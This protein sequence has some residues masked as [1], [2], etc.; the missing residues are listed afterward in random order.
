MLTPKHNSV[1][2]LLRKHA[3]LFASSNPFFT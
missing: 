3:V 1:S 2:P